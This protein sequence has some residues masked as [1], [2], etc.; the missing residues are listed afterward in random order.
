MFI[1]SHVCMSIV[2]GIPGEKGLIGEET[3]GK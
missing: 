1:Q 2:S 3:Y